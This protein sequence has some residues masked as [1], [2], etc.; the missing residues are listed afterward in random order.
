MSHKEMYCL[1]SYFVCQFPDSGYFSTTW[2]LE[3]VTKTNLSEQGKLLLAE[4][5]R[6]FLEVESKGYI[7]QENVGKKGNGKLINSR[8]PNSIKRDLSQLQGRWRRLKLQSK[9]DH[10]LHS[11][12]K[13]TTSWKVKSELKK[14]VQHLKTFSW[15]QPGSLGMTGIILFVSQ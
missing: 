3:Q 10:G 7:W 5:V 11:R 14:S 2:L 12:E 6:D 9:R 4:L 1:R 15:Y 13:W 8:K